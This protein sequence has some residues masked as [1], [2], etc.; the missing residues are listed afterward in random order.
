MGH[1]SH[2][3]PVELLDDVRP[4][5]EP[6]QRAADPVRRRRRRLL[7]PVV[8]V[9]TLALVGAQA[10]FLS[11]D[12][13]DAARIEALPGVVHGIDGDVAELWRVDERDLAY[14]D[15]A[16]TVGGA[17]IGVRTAPDGSQR[18]EARDAATGRRGWSAPL[19]GP[20]AELALRGGE[21]SPSECRSVPAAGGEAELVACLG[22][23]AVVSL[24]ERGRTTYVREPARSHVV[25][26]DASDGHVVSDQPAPPAIDLMTLPGLVVVG[27]PGEDGHAEVTAQDVATG[28][29]LW[30]FRSPP[31]GIA[32]AGD[33]AGFRLFPLGDEV[34][35][36]EARRQVTLLSASGQ[37]VREHSR[38]LDGLPVVVGDERLELLSGFAEG[39]PETTVVRPGRADAKVPG[40]LLSR[41]VDDGSL[42][43]VEITYGSMVRAWDAGSGELL[44]ESE[45]PIGGPAV[46]LNGLVYCMSGASA[47]AVL[48]FDGRTG[49]LVWSANTGSYDQVQTLLTNGRSL[50][51]AN[52]PATG[53]RSGTLDA[54]TL[55]TGTHVWRAV[56]PE[57]LGTASVQGKLLLV[58]SDVGAAVLGSPRAAGS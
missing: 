44:W 50:L 16:V 3:Q 57:R 4:P 6:P 22:S 39:R 19:R 25:V 8:G 45:G 10:A 7:W 37:V 15:R 33:V 29:R 53:E 46:I 47:G 21:A 24:G 17:V 41:S 20:D 54:F 58:G 23:D 1:R 48:A 49:A 12:R 9:D 26:V 42:D 27:R 35:V 18:V 51:V 52:S 13:A 43:D 55:D 32:P 5:D 28:D 34:G 11:R 14:L 2:M 38:V 30:Q 36:Q 40:Y 56:L 31:P